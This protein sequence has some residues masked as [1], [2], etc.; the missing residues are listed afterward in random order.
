MF[1]SALE[2]EGNFSAQDQG[3][4]QKVLRSLIRNLWAIWTYELYELMSYMNL[5]AI[6]TYELYELIFCKT[7]YLDTHS[8]TEAWTSSRL[9][10]ND[11]VQ[12]GRHLVEP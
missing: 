6:W 3:Y 7:L 8:F 5:W 2:K 10:G 12:N 1:S 4:L 9:K 11:I